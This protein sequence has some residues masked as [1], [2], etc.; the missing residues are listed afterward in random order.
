MSHHRE[1]IQT[2][3]EYFDAFHH[4][5]WAAFG[6][7]LSEDFTYFTDGMTILDKTKFVEFLSNDS[8]EGKEYKVYD[9]NIHL[10]RNSD[11]AVAAYKTSFTGMDNTKELIV[12]A[13][14]TSVFQK[15]NGSWKMIHS[16]TS[17]R[18][19]TNQNKDG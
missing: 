2:I 18:T 15:K 12:E 7:F 4:K 10:S 17:N 9:F 16:H 6:N 3:E 19:K 5:D 11:M 8:W 14:E 13:I 1:V